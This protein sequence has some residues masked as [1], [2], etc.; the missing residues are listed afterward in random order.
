[1]NENRRLLARFIP[2][3]F[4]HPPVESVAQLPTEILVQL[5]AMSNLADPA[6][7]LLTPGV[8]SAV[9]SEHSF[10]ARGMGI[11]LVQG[12]NLLVLDGSLFLKTVSGLERVDVCYS[13]VAEPWLYSLHFDTESPLG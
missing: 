10:L 1:M 5:R 12:E 13:R 9:Y 11:P 4:E 8:A 7:V 2:D 6:G 3:L